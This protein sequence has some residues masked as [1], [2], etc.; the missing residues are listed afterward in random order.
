RRA[1]SVG[2]LKLTA[3]VLMSAISVAF[4]A[5]ALIA[6]PPQLNAA[7]L[8]AFALACAGADRAWADRV[9]RFFGVTLAGASFALAI[10]ATR[11]IGG[12]EDLFGPYGQ[13]VLNFALPAALLGV[14]AHVVKRRP[15][16][17]GALETV[18]IAL[19]LAFATMGIRVGFAAG[20]PIL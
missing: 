4:C 14:A 3:W 2:A 1:G 15:Y 18:A 7:A 11:L 17:S 13:T 8:A 12:S 20:A 9:W 5:A 6:L 19:A 16:T 10:V